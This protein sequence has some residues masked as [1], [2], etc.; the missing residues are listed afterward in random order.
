MKFDFSHFLQAQSPV[1]EQVTVELKQGQKQSHW[2]WFVFPQLAGLGR[3]EMARR[4]ALHSL[5]EAREYLDHPL[6]GSRLRHS[7]GLVLNINDRLISQIFA[8]PDDLKFHSSMTL[9]ALAS[10]QDSV[11]TAALNK[12]FG[13]QRDAKTEELLRG[14]A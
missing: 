5:T 6:L 12:F 14:Q 4:F 10:P 7:T 8:F 2:M 13:G 3:S 9:F 11:F 1:Y